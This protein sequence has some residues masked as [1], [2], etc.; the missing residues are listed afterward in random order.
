[1][2]L[3]LARPLPDMANCLNMSQDRPAQTTCTAYLQGKGGAQGAAG[4]R[5]SALKRYMQTHNAVYT[6][7]AELLPAQA[8]VEV[9]HEAQRS[10][11]YQQR[12]QAPKQRKRLAFARYQPL[13]V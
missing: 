13:F 10:W 8:I 7:T 12:H 3:W 5:V 6:Q 4:G 2:S 1:M 11:V 9:G